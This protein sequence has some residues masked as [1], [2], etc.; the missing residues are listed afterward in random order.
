[1][2]FEQKGQ[3]S[4]LT[5]DDPRRPGLIERMKERIRRGPGHAGEDLD[6]MKEAL[7]RLTTPLLPDKI[8]GLIERLE[9]PMWV[10]GAAH[11]SA[12]LEVDVTRADMKEAAAAL[13][14]VAALEKRIGELESERDAMMKCV[15]EVKAE[16]DAMRALN[17]SLLAHNRE[18]LHDIGNPAAIRAKT[19]EECAREA[20]W[21]YNVQEYTYEDIAKRIRALAQTDDGNALICP[22]CGININSP[23][24]CEHAQTDEGKTETRK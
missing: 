16:R 15:I 18:L 4:T 17:A 8:V 19:I 20:D 6:L 7:S 9:H 3:T 21:F 10:H 13:S 11:A 12:Q 22:K 14:R 2:P 5:T 1:M 24:P 23:F